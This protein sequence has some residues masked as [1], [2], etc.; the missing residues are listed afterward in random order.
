MFSTIQNF[1]SFIP[2]IGTSY[3]VGVIYVS[4]LH[5]VI[6]T[7]FIIKMDKYIENYFVGVVYHLVYPIHVS[8]TFK[9][10]RLEIFWHLIEGQ[11]RVAAHI[12]SPR[13]TVPGSIISTSPHRA[14]LR[15]ILPHLKLLRERATFIV[16]LLCPSVSSRYF[17]LLD[18]ACAAVM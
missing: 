16:L 11:H 12:Q 13:L 15:P 4:F 7:Y 17:N 2:Y 1:L 14:A 9:C 18:S 3:K 6:C 5:V 8:K 10:E